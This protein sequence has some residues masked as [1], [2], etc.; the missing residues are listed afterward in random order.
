MDCCCC[1]PTHVDC[2]V[3]EIAISLQS[4]ASLAGLLQG[5][6][7]DFLSLYLFQRPSMEFEN[8]TRSDLAL[9]GSPWG[10]T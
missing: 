6:S 8:A 5:V 3:G 1:A 7:L 4:R 2:V 9:V 10:A